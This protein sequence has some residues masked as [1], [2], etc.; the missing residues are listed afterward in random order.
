MLLLEDYAPLHAVLHEIH[1]RAGEPA[2]IRKPSG[3]L[4]DE[5]NEPLPPAARMELLREAECLLQYENRSWMRLMI[6]A[7]WFG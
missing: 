5:S 4:A 6:E 2:P 1:E 3:P 7:E